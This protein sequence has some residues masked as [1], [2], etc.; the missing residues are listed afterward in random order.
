MTVWLP[1]L[2]VFLILGTLR[3]GGDGRKVDLGFVVVI[4][5]LTLIAW[6]GNS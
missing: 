6:S 3:K 5:V 2:I 4:L 1:L